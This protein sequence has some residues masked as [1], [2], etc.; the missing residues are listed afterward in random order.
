MQRLMSLFVVVV[1]VVLVSGA[2]AGAASSGCPSD[3]RAAV[4]QACP[5]DTA[6][7]HGYHMTCIRNQLK[8]LKKDGCEQ[9]QL[10]RAA[11]CANTSRCGKAHKPVVCC[12]KRGRA[13]LTSA[14]NCTA[15]GGRVMSGASSLCDAG[16]GVP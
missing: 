16:C 2:R 13:K 12:P 3:I 9:K 7:N 15:R 8:Q 10:Q 11:K 6:K 5:C 14:E 4:A 1:S